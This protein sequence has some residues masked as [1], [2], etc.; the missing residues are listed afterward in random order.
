MDLEDELRFQ[1]PR[2][3][4]PENGCGCTQATARVEAACH[5]YGEVLFNHDRARSMAEPK[6]VSHRTKR[7][8]RASV[9]N[10]GDLSATVKRTQ[11]FCRQAPVGR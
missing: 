7:V 5:R 3:S 9:P 11:A 4:E 10:V 6:G 8:G 1:R 2:D